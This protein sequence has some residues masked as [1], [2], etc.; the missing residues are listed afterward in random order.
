M[1]KLTRIFRKVTVYGM[2][3]TSTF[4]APVL[5]KVKFK[6]DEDGTLRLVEDEG[7]TCTEDIA[8]GHWQGWPDMDDHLYRYESIENLVGYEN[9]IDGKFWK[10]VTL[11][12]INSNTHTISGTRNDGAKFMYVNDFDI[13]DKRQF[14]QAC[15]EFNKMLRK[16]IHERA[17]IA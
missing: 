16:E 12:H 6:D 9:E 2:A 17:V 13:R 5:P 11:S 15:Q 1:N 14:D 3:L 7:V 10:S 4:G 8:Q